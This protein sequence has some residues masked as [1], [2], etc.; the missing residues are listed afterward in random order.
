[1]DVN[2]E[3]TVEATVDV[4]ASAGGK[5]QNGK[6]EVKVS[7]QLNDNAELASS[8]TDIRLRRDG[9]GMGAFVDSS[10]SYGSDGTTSAKLNDFNWFT[11]KPE[12]FTQNAQ[13]AAIFGLLIKQ[14]LLDAVA[15]GY[16][17]GRCVE[18]GYG[19]SPGTT[20]LQPGSSA[21]ITARPR[22]KQDG[23]PTGGTVQALLSAGGK[24]VDPSS[25][26]IP[27]DAEFGYSA[28]DEPNKTGT[29]SLE[30]RSKRG[31]G[32]VDINFDTNQTAAYQVV[33]GLD[34]WQTNTAVCDIMQPFVLTGIVT[35]NFSGGLS[36]TYEYSGGPFNATGSGTYQISL[37]DGPGQAGAM[38]GTGAGSVDTPMG[39]FSN[40]GTEQYTLTPIP[41]C[42]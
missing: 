4:S 36:G 39:Q 24:A 28:P 22:G 7:G 9:L 8:T 1:P 37:P 42:E 11:T 23:V 3:F 19:V 16:M 13:L 33:G 14:Y 41:P 12:D 35:M 40:S 18:I 15:V 31:I 25:T 38:T 21:T 34:D 26:P 27:V 20:G 10:I 17:S 5:E 2:G 6:L 29:V 32:R 30:S